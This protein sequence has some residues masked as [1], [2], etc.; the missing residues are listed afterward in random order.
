MIQRRL[1]ILCLLLLTLLGADARDAGSVTGTIIGTKNE[2]LQGFTVY[3][4]QDEPLSV[5]RGQPGGKTADSA[6]A[7]PLAEKVL[8]KAISDAKGNFKFS[9]VQ[10]GA[11]LLRGGNKQNGFIY[12]PFTIEPNETKDV[13]KLKIAIF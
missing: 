2:I 11:Y 7:K 9:N 12:Q 13:G 8:D 3:L 10:R 4:V 5:P 6:P 1:P